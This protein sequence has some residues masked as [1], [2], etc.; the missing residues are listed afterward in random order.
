MKVFVTADNHFFHK[1]IIKYCKRPFNSVRE[2]NDYMIKR[3]NKKVTK[4]DLVFH[5]GDFAFTTTEN[6]IKVRRKINGTIIIIPGNH[7][8]KKMMRECG[9]IVSPTNIIRIDNIVLTHRPLPVVHSG[10]VNVHGHIHEK[11]THGKRINASVDV[12]GFEPKPIEKYFK[13]AGRILKGHK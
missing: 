8:R 13:E 6:L 7:D 4:K 2:M 3:W 11:N 5:L 10:V 9:F 1:N 12:T